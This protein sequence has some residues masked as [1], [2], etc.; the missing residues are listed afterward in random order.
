M[1]GRLG[2][3]GRAQSEIFR[4]RYLKLATAA[5]SLS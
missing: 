2:M 1:R 3:P 5:A 4:G